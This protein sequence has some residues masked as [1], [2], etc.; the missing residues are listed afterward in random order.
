[1]K[2]L[3]KISGP[4]EHLGKLLLRYH[5]GLVTPIGLRNHEPQLVIGH[6]LAEFDG[7]PPQVL[8]GDEL[9]VLGGEQLEGSL[10]LLL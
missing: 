3:S 9:L 1:M 8:E 2:T 5:I 10:D 4:G 7:D 6:G